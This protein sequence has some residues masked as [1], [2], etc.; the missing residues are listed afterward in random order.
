[1][2]ESQKEKRDSCVKMADRFLVLSSQN[3]ILNEQTKN[4]ISLCLMVAFF[5]MGW[6][7]ALEAMEKK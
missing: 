4:E 2:K 7:Q 3:Q 1:M 6:E 5:D